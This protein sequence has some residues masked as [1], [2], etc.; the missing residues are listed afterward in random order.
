MKRVQILELVQDG[1]LRCEHFCTCRDLEVHGMGHL[2]RVS[3]TAG[4][5]AAILD[6]D[7]ESAVVG[8]FLHDCARTDDGGG[9]SHA[10]SSAQLAKDIMITCYPHLDIARLCRG[11]AQHADGMITDDP[12]IGCVWDAD[13]LDLS[14]LGIEVDLDL[15]STFVARRLVMLQRSVWS[16]VSRLW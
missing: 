14:R 9:T 6:E 11:I 16:A 5:M 10:H 13:R 2:R 7:I 15:L 4:R 12:L 1:E 3:S 8:G